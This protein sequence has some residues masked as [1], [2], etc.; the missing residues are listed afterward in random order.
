M[1]RAKKKADP[2]DPQ[3]DAV[4]SWEAAHESWNVCT[5]DIEQCEYVA[6]Q[7][8]KL[9]GCEPIDMQNG[10]PAR[11][12]WNIP[13]WRMICMQGPSRRGR[14]GRNVATVLHEAAHQIVFDLYADNTQD[15]GPTFLGVY[16]ELLLA[17][18]VLTPREFD[19]SARHYRLKWRPNL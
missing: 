17:A 10:S 1:R 6:Q 11:F 12:S 18:K 3:K 7:A 4:Y 14:G 2:N 5:L 9:F 13:A 15:H 16:R 8:L 19:V